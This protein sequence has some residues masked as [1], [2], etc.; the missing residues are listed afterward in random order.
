MSETSG[1]VDVIDELLQKTKRAI[2]LHSPNSEKCSKLTNQINEIL[3]G[4]KDFERPDAYTITDEICYILEHFEFDSAKASRK[5][6]STRIESARVEK[7]FNELVMEK[8]RAGEQK[9][10]YNDS[11]NV[12][13]SSCDYVN[14]ALKHVE[15]HYKKIDSYI[16]NLCD[17]NIITTQE[18][19]TGFFIEDKTALGNA[20][21]H[22][23]KEVRSA[24]V[25]PI[26]LCLT[27]QF[28]DW[29]VDAEKLDFCF[30]ASNYGSDYFIYYIS[31]DLIEEY[32]KHEIDMDNVEI[33]DF[34]P[35]VVGFHNVIS[36]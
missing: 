23:S 4:V 32:R 21:N 6:S 9:V 30:C 15:S 34:Q 17:A 1:L 3:S 36:D 12:S 5:G 29:F 7:G 35:Q 16:N 20:Y 14:N 13:H 27:K 22:R 33:M 8:L 31:R 2:K 24:E 26:V 25:R 28:L 18:V 11:Y 10:T 19:K